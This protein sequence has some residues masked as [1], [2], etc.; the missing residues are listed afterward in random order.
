V[1][2]QHSLLKKDICLTHIY[3][4]FLQKLDFPEDFETHTNSNEAK[5][6]KM[7]DVKKLRCSR[8]GY[9]LVPLCNPCTFDELA[10]F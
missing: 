5:K 9:K 10:K 7:M 3:Y 1:K 8:M 2:F 6:K 4:S